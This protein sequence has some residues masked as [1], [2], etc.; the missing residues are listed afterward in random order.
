[1]VRRLDEGYGGHGKFVRDICSSGNTDT[2]ASV[3]FDKTAKIWL[4]D[5]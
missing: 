5:V 4:S 2:V 3:S 1:M